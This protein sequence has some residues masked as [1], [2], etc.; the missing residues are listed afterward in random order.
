MTKKC[1]A[2]WNIDI[3]K[4]Q[5]NTFITVKHVL[6]GLKLVR[7]TQRDSKVVYKEMMKKLTEKIDKEGIKR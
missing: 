7:C 4:G 6:T 3:W 1:W 2:N 5:I